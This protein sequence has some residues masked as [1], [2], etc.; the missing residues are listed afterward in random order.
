MRE[1]GD[2]LMLE[3]ENVLMGFSTLINV[4]IN[5]IS[6]IKQPV[7]D[8]QA[9]DA[10]VVGGVEVGGEGVRTTLGIFGQFR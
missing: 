7:D 5:S 1:C 8:V 10:V 2:V 9:L 6:V 4:A 3:C